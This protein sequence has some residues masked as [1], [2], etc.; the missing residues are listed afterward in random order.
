[1]LAGVALRAIYTTVFLMSDLRFDW[2]PSLSSPLIDERLELLVQEALKD[3]K[4]GAGIQPRATYEASYRAIGKHLI[5]A[6]YCAYHAKERIS[7]PMRPS[8]YGMG[9]LGGI[10]YSFRDTS[11]VREVLV[12]LGWL[13]VEE[14]GTQGKY[15]LVAASGDLTR[16]FEDWG[17]RWMLPELLPEQAC[18]SLRDVK[19]DTEGKPIRSG[20]KKLTTKVELEVPESPLVAQH[21]SNLTY[22]NNKLRQHCISLDLSNEHLMQ[23]QK[24]MSQGKTND[25]QGAYSSIQ[26]QNVQLTRIFSR[27][28]MELGG[29]FYRGWWQSIPS[30]HRPHIRI[31]GKKTIEVDYSGMCLR[32]LY[33]LAGQEMSLEDDPYDIGL[34]NWEGRGDKRRSNIKKIINALINDE[35][36]VFVIPKKALKL[37]E[38]TE[39][40][41]NSLLTKKH[42]LIAEQLNSGV[43]L[44]AQYIDSQIAEAVMLELMKEDIVVLPVHDS[45]IVPAGYQSTLEASMNY[46]FDRITGSS[47]IVEAELVKTDEH[48]G[49]SSDELLELQN[50]EG[51]SVGI[52]NGEQTLEAVVGYQH[53]I[54]SK[55]LASWELWLAS[56]GLTAISS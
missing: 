34:E 27:G 36:D 20:M 49:M 48:F 43:G 38:V 45:F 7:L 6:L 8:A 55:Y 53:R 1:M 46:H 25:P 15:T 32:I 4:S 13:S 22:I 2:H 28:S 42:P 5:S 11:K 12:S 16:A 24:E 9:K 47:S 37:L 52:T 21:R 3:Y 17:L 33:A 18:V 29:R 14:E 23:L 31:D 30:K 51:E 40:Q 19:R 35:D 39:E 10:H 50:Q 56:D 26:L 41:F 54:M 44:K